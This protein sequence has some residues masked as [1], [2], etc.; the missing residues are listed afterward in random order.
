[1]PGIA[2]DAGVV[3]QLELAGAPQ[4]VIDEARARVAAAD[5][6]ADFEVWED[7][8]NAW[9]F[10]LSLRGQWQHAVGMAGMARTGL[11]FDRVLSAMVMQPI[12]RVARPQLYDDIKRMEEAV[13]MA[14]RSIAKKKAAAT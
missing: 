10:F 5:Q 6:V 11:P 3:D 9:L 13:L 4:D 2:P 1:M 12:A 14:D 7:C 8:W